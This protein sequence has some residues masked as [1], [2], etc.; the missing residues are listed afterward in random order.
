MQDW[1]PSTSALSSYHDNFLKDQ[2]K[3]LIVAK[4]FANLYLDSSLANTMQETYRFVYVETFIQ[5]F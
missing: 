3:A 2:K 1:L 5:V 4:E